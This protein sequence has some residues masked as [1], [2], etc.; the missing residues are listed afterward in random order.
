MPFP[1]IHCRVPLCEHSSVR[2]HMLRINR[3][4]FLIIPSYLTQYHIILFNSL[5]EEENKVTFSLHAIIYIYYNYL[6]S[7]GPLQIVTHILCKSNNC[8]IIFITTE[9]LPIIEI[10]IIAFKVKL[11]TSHILAI[12]YDFKQLFNLLGILLISTISW[13][14]WWCWRSEWQHC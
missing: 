2:S 10:V 7:E 8:G 14:I 13:F 4:T 5:V 3:R 12:A 11:I 1:T 6:T 9:S